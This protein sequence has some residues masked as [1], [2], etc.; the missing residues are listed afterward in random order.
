MAQFKFKLDKWSALLGLF[1]VVVFIALPVPSYIFIESWLIG[2]I[3]SLMILIL[4][5]G[6]IVFIL[7]THRHV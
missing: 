1:L 6:A 2:P 3:T 5:V 7:R 4:N